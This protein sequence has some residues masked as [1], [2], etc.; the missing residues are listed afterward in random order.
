MSRTTKGAST[1]TRSLTVATAFISRAKLGV[2]GLR[3]SS[4]APSGAFWMMPSSPKYR[5]SRCVVLVQ[6]DT[7][8]STSAPSAAAVKPAASRRGSTARRK[9]SL[10]W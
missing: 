8:S 4:T 5:S 3:S 2:V 7:T 9:P 6:N 1:I 10:P